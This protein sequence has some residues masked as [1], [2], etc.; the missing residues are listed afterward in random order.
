VTL[1]F[2]QDW[3]L[4]HMRCPLCTA[5]PLPYSPPEWSCE[6]CGER[7]ALVKNSANFITKEMSTDFN[8]VENEN[9]S[10]HPYN[11]S[12]R[13][14]ID[15]VRVI[16]GMA[17]DCGAGSRTFVDQHLIQVEIMPYDNIDVMAVNQ[18]L[19]FVDDCFDAVFSFDV[20]E[21]VNDPFASARELSRV[22]KPGGILYIDLP[23]LQIEH[24]YPHHYFNATRMGLRQLFNG[25]LAPQAHVVPASGHP[26]HVIWMALNTF[27][28]GLP[29]ELRMPFAEM[30]IADIL[31]KPWKE[32]RDSEFGRQ[33]D[34]AVAWRIASTTQA[35]FRKDAASRGEVSRLNIAVNELPNF[36]GR[37]SNLN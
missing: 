20:L 37:V 36:K 5:H 31:D 6:S 1:D 25:M 19:P 15:E 13:Q 33:L 28:S 17:L 23:F 35:I 8:I 3:L 14:I 11:P 2:K 34:D 21:H 24:G 9:T 18:Q 4:R 16:G 32:L 10:D 7:Y 30:T 27:R 22:L 12:A 29:R 26:A